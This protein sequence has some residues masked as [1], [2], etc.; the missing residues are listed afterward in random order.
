MKDIDQYAYRSNLRMISPSQKALFAFGTLLLCVMS[1]SL[2]LSLVVIVMMIF[3]SVKKGGADIGMMMKMMSIPMAFLVIS[4]VTILFEVSATPNPLLLYI[5][6]G[7]CYI[8]FTWNGILRVTYLFF[9]VMASISCL[10][11]FALSTPIIDFL[12]VL[13]NIKCPAVLV[14][15][16]GLIYRFIF[17]LIEA[18]YIMQNAQTSRL[19]YCNF[20][21]GIRSFGLLM[22]SVL[23]R[24]LK[25][26]NDLYVSLE[27]RGYTGSLRVLRAD[28]YQT[29][30]P[31]KIIITE[32]LL[33]SLVVIEKCA[34]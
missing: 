8:G 16:M 5:E 34:F 30:S 20:K 17:V 33:V 10:Y 23:V 1:N 22:S 14:E 21:T 12:E 13:E 27:S 7:K 11:F 29:I 18:T 6:I 26:N 28:T 15:M 24:A 32:I 4:M 2:L 19:G 3:V 9:K 25:I 31:K